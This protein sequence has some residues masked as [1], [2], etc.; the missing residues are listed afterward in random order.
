MET[1]TSIVLYIA[2]FSG[3]YYQI[4][5]LV[6]FFEEFEEKA[7]EGTEQRRIDDASLPTVSIT[8]PCWNEGRTVEKT[9]LSLLALDYPKDKLSILIVDDGSTDNT[10]E[11]ARRLARRY[12]IVRAVRQENGGKFTALNRGIQTS[13]SE[14]FSCLDA[15]SAVHPQ[16]LRRMI[17]Y[18]TSDKVMAVTPALRV[19]EPRGILQRLQRIEYNIGVF[20]KKMLG[21]NDAI[22]VTPGPFSLFRR[23]VFGEIG[24]FHHAHNTEDMEI[25][26]RIQA[27]GYRIENCH[28]AY[29]ETITPNTLKKLYRQRTRWTY[30]FI[31]NCIDYRSFFFN[32]RYGNMGLFTLPVAIL[33]ITTALILTGIALYHFIKN[34]LYHLQ[35]MNMV[36]IHL[37]MPSMSW[38]YMNTETAGILALFLLAFGISIMFIGQKMSDNGSKPSLD[39]LYFLVAYGFIAPLWLGKAVYNTVTSRKTPWR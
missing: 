34:S 31:Q 23:S 32:K 35:Q 5:L 6:T 27:R 38:F 24:L 25:A 13:T 22:H 9:V 19:S 36:G 28:D 14:F 37:S 1:F 2:L 33:S 39:M 20:S 10:F 29:V 16:A 12:S 8:V 17:P 15:D 30:G 26:F 4:F 3:L 18:F 7:S 21:L 11:I